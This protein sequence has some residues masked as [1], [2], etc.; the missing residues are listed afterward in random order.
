M[1]LMCN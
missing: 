1:E